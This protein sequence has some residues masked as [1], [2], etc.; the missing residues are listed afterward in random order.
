[1]I[2]AALLS[3]AFC[4]SPV[5]AQEMT[6]SERLRALSAPAPTDFYE[7]ERQGDLNLIASHAP[8][9]FGDDGA[10]IVMFSGPE[11]GSC[12]TA[13]TDLQDMA[14]AQG[15]PVRLLDTGEPENAA[16]MQALTL[17][18][19]PS[20]VMRDRLIRGEMPAFVLG[21]YLAE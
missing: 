12:G 15:V 13:W 14:Q 21:R 1:M 19:L 16:L 7:D 20:Y 3:C 11:C 2:R 5:L 4:A 17:D 8:A 18:T 6:L 9:L 10:V